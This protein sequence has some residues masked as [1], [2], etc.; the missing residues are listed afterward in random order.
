MVLSFAPSV[1][2]FAEAETNTQTA[3]LKALQK[4]LARMTP[5][6]NQSTAGVL[7]PEQMRE[8]IKDGVTWF[9]QAQ[10][11][12]GHFAYEYLPYEDTY[13]SDDNIVR[14]A[15][16][17]YALGE[18]VRRSATQDKNTNKTIEQAIT[19]FENQSPEDTYEG[20]NIR[21]ITNTEESSVCKLGATALAL[22]GILGYVEGNPSKKDTYEDLIDAYVSYIL[23]SKKP[24][25]GFRNQYKVGTG[26]RDEKESSFS[27]GEALLALVRYYQYREDVKVKKVIDETFM[28]LK[29]TPFDTGLY[30]W[31]MA[32]LKDMQV[33]W[34][35]DAYITY[36]RDFTLW[37]LNQSLSAHGST[38]NYCALGE[39][40]V[41]AYS[42]LDGK[43]T[44]SEKKKLRGEIDFWNTR[45][46]DLQ[47]KKEDTYKLAI[48]N[49]MPVLKKVLDMKQSAGGFLTA[50]TELTQRIDF[51]QHCI[52]TYLQTLVDVD[53][54]T[55]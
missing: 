27:N 51:T 15:G 45:N 34:P 19:F 6:P 13:R 48:E 18:V 5:A 1:V 7:T 47:I 49:K 12:N 38:R 44:E 42:L 41:S 16:G 11:P 26:F 39:G 14:Q 40:L 2:V 52:T 30:L 33:L 23:V 46:L 10:E 55:L 22:T 50:D 36:G 54:G 32:G 35:N 21:C 31:M 28:Y 17:L 4:Y 9:T 25:L 53:G 3:Q 20:K 8:A 29:S 24:T 37:R 43:I